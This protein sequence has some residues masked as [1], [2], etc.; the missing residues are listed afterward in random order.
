MATLVDPAWEA[1]AHDWARFARSPEHD[2]FFWS[3]NGPRFLEIVP[4]PGRCTIDVACGEGRVGRLLRER[5]HRVVAVD[6][7][8]A[9][10]RL[11][12]EA[13]GQSVLVGDASR[14][15][16]ATGTADLAIAFMSL[17]DIG[18]LDAAV[19]EVAR[20]L[21]EGG[22]FCVAIAHPIRSAGSFSGK[23]ADSDFSLSSYF[24]PRPWPWRSRHTGI[25]IELPGIHRPLDAY[26]AALEREHFA[27]ETLREPQPS[28]DQ[29]SLHPE[30]E[31]W[32]RIPCFLH[33]RA[34][35]RK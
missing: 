1:K 2:H 9:M 30:S 12:Q 26:T 8:R 7:T 22:R 33:I 18:D 35:R 11:A 15:P 19:A 10:A 28:P 34:V 24:E 13:G 3:F 29:A 17:Q 23:H 6:G 21:I 14:L 31:R 20:V 32:R 5:G 27:I 25:E 16:I 4:P